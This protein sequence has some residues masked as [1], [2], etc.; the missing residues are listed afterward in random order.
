M[1]EAVP[2][3]R[4]FV[5]GVL[6]RWHEDALV[7]DANVIVSELASNAVLHAHSPFRV[8]IDRSVGMVCISIQDVAADLAQ[9]QPE[10]IEPGG[11]GMV[12][13][14][15]LSRRWGCDTLPGGKVVW[16]ELSATGTDV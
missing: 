15:A 5:S 16:A 10:S 7:P 8:S 14:E 3:T 2:A 12:I 6:A 9:Q 13:V 4:R 11:R 1:A